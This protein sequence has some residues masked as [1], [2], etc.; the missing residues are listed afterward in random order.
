M[1]LVY[2]YTQHPVLHSASSVLDAQKLRTLKGTLH[3]WIWHV[4]IYKAHQTVC[5]MFIAGDCFRTGWRLL[6]NASNHTPCLLMETGVE[7]NTDFSLQKCIKKRRNC[8]CTLLVD[9]QR[10]ATWPCWSSEIGEE[11]DKGLSTCSS[12][13]G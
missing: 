7:Q 3:D 4:C 5:S 8:A 2:A 6:T 10:W 11:A 12:C 13:I 9:A 1:K